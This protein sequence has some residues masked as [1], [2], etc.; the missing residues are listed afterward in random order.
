MG[1]AITRSDT[2]KRERGG[3]RWAEDTGNTDC[4]S[5]SSL[6]QAGREAALLAGGKSLRD[7]RDWPHSGLCGG[8]THSILVESDGNEYLKVWDHKLWDMRKH[9]QL[10]PAGDTPLHNVHMVMAA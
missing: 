9:P 1:N 8:S 10:K 4:I 5:S 2:R 6:H 3:N 7:C